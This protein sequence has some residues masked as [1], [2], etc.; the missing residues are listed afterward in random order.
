VTRRDKLK[1]FNIAVKTLPL[2]IG[3]AIGWAD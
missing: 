2:S 1:R 3:L